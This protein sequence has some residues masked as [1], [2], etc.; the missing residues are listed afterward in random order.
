MLLLGGLDTESATL[1]LRTWWDG[2]TRQSPTSLDEDQIGGRGGG[3][4]GGGE[5]QLLLE[6]YTPSPP[7]P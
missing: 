6:D 4:V 5:R 7:P 1:R 2:M 3:V